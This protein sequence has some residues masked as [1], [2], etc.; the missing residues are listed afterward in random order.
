MRG[1]TRAT[2]AQHLRNP[3]F[4]PSIPEDGN[5]ATGAGVTPLQQKKVFDHQKPVTNGVD[6]AMFKFRLLMGN[7]GSYR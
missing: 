4:L 5:S 3:L 6:Q 1:G 2:M 7:V